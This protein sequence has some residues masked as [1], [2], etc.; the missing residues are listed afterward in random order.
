MNNQPDPAT[1]RVDDL[2]GWLGV[3]P[4]ND[5]DAVIYGLDE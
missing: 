2:I 5:I 1:G 3:E 4:D